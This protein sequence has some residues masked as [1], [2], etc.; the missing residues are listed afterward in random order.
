MKQLFGIDK[1]L[2]PK[3]MFLVTLQCVQLVVVVCVSLMWLTVVVLSRLC[4]AAVCSTI[5]SFTLLFLITYTVGGT[6]NHSLTLGMH[7]ISHN[8]AFKR[9]LHNR[10]L[11][12][13][14][15]LPLGVPSFVSFKRYHM[16]HHKYQVCTAPAP[17]SLLPAPSCLSLTQTFCFPLFLYGRVKTAWIRTS[18]RTWRSACSPT[19]S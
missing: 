1:M 13:F 4:M 17:C 6:I 7:E 12:V 11:G 15:N 16:D 3:V 9:L 14:C 10:I 19:P 5:E 2:A 18:R 8:L